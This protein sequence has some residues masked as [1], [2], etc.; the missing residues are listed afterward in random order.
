MDDSVVRSEPGSVDESRPAK[1]PRL[2]PS[3]STV[4]VA[5]SPVS[6]TPAFEAPDGSLVR[7][8]AP[9]V[10]SGANE[11][12]TEIKADNAGGLP[13]NRGAAPIKAE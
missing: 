10:Q 9:A 8:T 7:E 2:T 5:G 12:D 3:D 11:A 4:A 1:R 13:K 6:E